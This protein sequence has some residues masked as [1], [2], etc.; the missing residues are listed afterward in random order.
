MKTIKKGHLEYPLD[1]LEHIVRNTVGKLK[2][3]DNKES[4]LIP[5]TERIHLIKDYETMPIDRSYDNPLALNHVT[6]GIIKTYTVDTTE[7]YIKKYF[8]FNDTQIKTN[9]INGKICIN[10]PN[11]NNNATEVI[12]KKWNIVAIFW[13]ILQKKY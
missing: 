1:Y 10:I 5:I 3:Q 9:D 6:E 4:L 7:R 2:V 11:I 13:H 8:G 12:K